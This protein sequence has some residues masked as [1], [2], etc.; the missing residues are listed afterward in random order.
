MLRKIITGFHAVE[1]RVLKAKQNK[2]DS[3]KIEIFYSKIGPR[4]KKII[5]IAKESEIPC[6]LVSELELNQMVKDLPLPQGHG[7]FLPIFSPSRFTVVVM[8]F[9]AT[10]FHSPLIFLNAAT[11]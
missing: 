4:V 9:P 5:S 11:S 7:S 10:Y 1:E 6:T 2:S 3:Q 8:M